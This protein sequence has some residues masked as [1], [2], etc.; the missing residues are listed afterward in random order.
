MRDLKHLI[1]FENL[2]QEANTLGRMWVRRNYI[3]EMNPIEALTDV[4]RRMEN[5]LNN[6]EFLA[7][8]N[9]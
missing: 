6:D 1:A 4:K 8:M 2:L 5:T 9:G 3:S 7:S